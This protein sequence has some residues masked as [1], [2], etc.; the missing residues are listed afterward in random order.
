MPPKQSIRHARPVEHHA[1][2]PDASYYGHAHQ[3]GRNAADATQRLKLLRTVVVAAPLIVVSSYILYKRT[4]LGEE[5]K[6]IPRAQLGADAIIA[7]E[8]KRSS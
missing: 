2:G 4:V 3:A 6:R 7:D 8:T 1:Q 5:Q